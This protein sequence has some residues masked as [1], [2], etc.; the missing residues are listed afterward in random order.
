MELG[1]RTHHECPACRAKLAS[2]RDSKPDLKFDILIKKL[3]SIAESKVEKVEDAKIS[4]KNLMNDISKTMSLE[5]IRNAEKSHQAKVKQLKEWAKS[6]RHLTSESIQ[7]DNKKSKNS[8]NSATPPPS[9]S[10]SIIQFT[11]LP[12]NEV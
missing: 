6:K 10:A 11:L 9:S 1:P 12:W 3:S 5:D 4:G 7:L 2:R 8:S